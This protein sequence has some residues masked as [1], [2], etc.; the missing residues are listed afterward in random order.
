M[1]Q[2][3]IDFDAVLPVDP[4]AHPADRPRLRGLN[5]KVLERLREGAATN[6]ELNKICLRYGARIHDLR[7][8]GFQIGSERVE[9]GQWKFWLISEPR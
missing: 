7:Q 1:H 9:A 8:A 6:F 4:N 5:A 3:T 2:T